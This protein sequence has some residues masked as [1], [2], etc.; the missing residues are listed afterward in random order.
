MPIL[1]EQHC[2]N[3]SKHAQV[4][5]MTSGRDAVTKYDCLLLQ[6]VFWKHPEEAAKIEEWFVDYFVTPGADVDQVCQ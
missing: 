6:H 2:L 4:A 1:R 3:E 5:A